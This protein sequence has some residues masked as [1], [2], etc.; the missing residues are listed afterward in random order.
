MKLTSI[1]LYEDTKKKL[2]SKKLHPRES[3]DSVLK[4]MFQIENIP[5]MDDMFKLGDQIKQNRNYSNKQ[6]IEISH[7]LRGKKWQNS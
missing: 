2:E 6:I 3:Y 7:G 5:L 4:R 1:Q